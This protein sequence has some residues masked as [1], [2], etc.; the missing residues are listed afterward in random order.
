MTVTDYW[1]TVYLIIGMAVFYICLIKIG[2]QFL[3]FKN[4]RL[5]VSVFATIAA[6][7]LDIV[8]QCMVDHYLVQSVCSQAIAVLLFFAIFQGDRWEKL[9]LAGALVSLWNFFSNAIFSVISICICALSLINNGI[10]GQHFQVEEGISVAAYLLITAVFVFVLFHKTKLSEG[11]FMRGGR[12]LIFTNGLL[13]LLQDICGFGITRGVMLVADNGPEYW[14]ITRNEMFTHLEVLVIASLCM[15]ICLTMLFG[16]NRLV[17]YITTEGLHKMEINRYQA[18]LVQYRDRI[19]VKHDMKNHLLAMSALAEHKEW[20]KLKEYLS[21]VSQTGILNDE[22]IETGNIIVNAIV[23]MNRQTAEELGIGFECDVH[24]TKALSMDDYDLCIIWGNILDNA[25]A[26]ADRAEEDKYVRI[27]AEIVKSNLLINV[28]NSV[29]Q[30][31]LKDDFGEC[32]YGTGLM[33][34]KKIVQKEKGVLD[35]QTAGDVFEITVLLPVAGVPVAS[36]APIA[37][38]YDE[39]ETV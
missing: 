6:I 16:M 23:N 36:A 34:V 13:L 8:I 12:L 31:G 18:I 20:D 4:K 30:G 26:A 38:V 9:G 14:N 21:K 25:L 3:L 28:K 29:Q 32:D 10:R 33:N 7:A 2:R 19:C 15:I 24:I 22:D 35:I 27:Q 5:I 39:K 37:P 11:N 1:Q 17:E